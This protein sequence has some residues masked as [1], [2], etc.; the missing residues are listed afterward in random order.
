MYVS[1]NQSPQLLSTK[2]NICVL[3][4]SKNVLYQTSYCNQNQGQSE[5]GA[6]I[7]RIVYARVREDLKY[8]NNP[9]YIYSSFFTLPLGYAPMAK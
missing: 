1:D 4:A 6:A 3:N 9:Y 5:N 7:L 8:T 2:T